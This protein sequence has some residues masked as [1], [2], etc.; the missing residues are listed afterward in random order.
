MT[1]EVKFYDHFEGEMRFK[2]INN[3]KI[4]VLESRQVPGLMLMDGPFYKDQIYK[5][6]LL[7]NNKIKHP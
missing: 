4:Y 5:T 2:N 6:E 3:G 7:E 1:V